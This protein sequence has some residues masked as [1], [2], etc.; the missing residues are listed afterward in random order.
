MGMNWLKTAGLGIAVSCALL[1]FLSACSEQKVL[2]AK[3]ACRFLSREERLKHLGETITFEGEYTSDHMERSVVGVVGCRSAIGVESMDPETQAA[4]DRLDRPEDAKK[5]FTGIRGQFTATL[6]R[7]EPNSLLYF[8]DDGIRLD[9]HR[10]EHPAAFT[11]V[12]QL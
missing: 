10:L 9:V 12:P 4:I 3:E 2:S 11:W 1:P 5:G 6:A 8:H 7:K